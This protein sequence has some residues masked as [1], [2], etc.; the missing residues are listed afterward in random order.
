MDWTH[1]SRAGAFDLVARHWDEDTV[2]A[3]DLGVAFPR[4]VASRT[5]LGTISRSAAGPTGLSEDVAVVAGGHDHLCAAYA[6]GLRTTAELFVSAGTSEAHL[7]LIQAPVEARPGHLPI[8]QGCYVD[9][10]TYYVHLPVPSGHVFQQWRSLLYADAD[11]QMLYAEV[12]RVAPGAG[13]IR[14]DLLDDLRYGR[15]DRLP[16]TADR[17]TVMCAVLEGLARRSADVVRTLEEETGGR[18][19]R[20]VVAGHPTRVPYWR[21][22]RMATYGRPIA[23]VDESETAAMGAAILAAEAVGVPD[24]DR[25]VARRVRWRRGC[26]VAGSEVL[27]AR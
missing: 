22:L 5:I 11:E 16:Y 26:R 12:A 3:A 1:A 10:G 21:A 2:Q 23:A 6:A 19:E 15:L 25:L 9:S 18:F 27:H 17:A 8:D 4:L 14:F 24:P 7:A 13:G 20:I